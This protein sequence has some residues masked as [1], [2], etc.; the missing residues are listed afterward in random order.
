MHALQPSGELI[1]RLKERR[2]M[3]IEEVKRVVEG[4]YGKFAE[5]G[6]RK[7]PC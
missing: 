3:R 7:E 6:G 1:L 5:T 2:T 4:R